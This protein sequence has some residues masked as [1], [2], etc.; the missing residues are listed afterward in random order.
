MDM[1]LDMPV[2]SVLL[3]QQRAWSRPI[4]DIVNDLLARAQSMDH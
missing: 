2:V 3:F 4:D 1:M